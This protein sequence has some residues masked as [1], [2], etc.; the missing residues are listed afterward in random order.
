MALQAFLR[1]KTSR[2]WAPFRVRARAPIQPHY[3]AAFALS[4][5]LCPH[6]QQRPLRSAC[7]CHTDQRRRYGF[8]EFHTCHKDGLGPAYSP[9]TQCQRAP[10]CKKDNQSH[11]I[12]VE[13]CQQLWLHAVDGVYQQFT[14]I[15]HTNQP[16]V[17]PA[18]CSQ[19]LHG[20]SRWPY[21][22]NIVGLHCQEASHP[23]VASDALSLGYFWLNKRSLH[24]PSCDVWLRQ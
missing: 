3:R 7:R 24:R 1:L 21:T 23:T 5:L 10:R 14:C 13:A 20:T 11:T 6:L 22:T 12:L 4:D 2:K 18:R 17:S 9:V 8:T 16:S 15:D 19:G